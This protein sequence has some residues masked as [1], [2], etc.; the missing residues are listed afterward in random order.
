MLSIRLPEDIE[1]R[2]GMLAEQTG[3]TKTYYAKKAIME[4][5]DDMEALYIAV[6]RT[7][8]PGKVWTLEEMEQ[9]LGLDD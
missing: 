1:Q 8:N 4:A 9:E 5:L 7:E 3:R 2:L 6:E